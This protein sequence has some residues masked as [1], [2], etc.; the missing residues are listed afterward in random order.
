MSQ[1]PET[2][3]H[4]RRTASAIAAAFACLALMPAAVG[5][6]NIPR[7]SV[8]P[9]LEPPSA[10]ELFLV[11][12][13]V[14]TQNYVCLVSPT[15]T[16][17]WAPIGP[18]ATLFDDRG[19]QIATHFASLNPWEPETSRPTW[20]HSRDT[21][22]VWAAISERSSDPEFVEPGAVDWLLLDVVGRRGRQTGV[23]RLTDTTYLQRVHTTGGV[24]PQRS[25][26][27]GDTAFVPYTADYYFYRLP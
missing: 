11:G 16:A 23:D 5:A 18:Q 2:T 19:V 17:S 8:P 3:L 27:E 22:A 20:Q 21:S 12:H 25:C 6:K 10:H 9:D 26:N 1:L 24:K 13:A 15:G 7:P 4:G 14:G